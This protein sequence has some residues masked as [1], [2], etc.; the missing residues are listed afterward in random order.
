MYHNAHLDAVGEYC[1]PPRIITA[2][3]TSWFKLLSQEQL[4]TSYIDEDA[5]NYN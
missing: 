3:K 1:H 5:Y 2:R 4:S